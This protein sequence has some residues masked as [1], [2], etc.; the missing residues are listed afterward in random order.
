MDIQNLKDY[1][2]ENG[3][4]STVLENLGCHHIAKK[5][6]YYTAGNPDGD[7]PCA[8]SVYE[9][10]YLTTVNYTRNI[11]DNKRSSDIFDLVQFFEEC[12]FFSAVKVVCDW[13]GVDYYSDPTDDLPE[14]LRITK[15]ILDMQKGDDIEDEDKP[16]RPISEKIL[17]YYL[18]CVNDMFK[19]DGISYT[20]QQEFEIGYDESTN[21]ITIPIRDELGTL[22]GVKGRQMKHTFQKDEN[23]YYY[24]EHTNRS[25]IL[26]GLNKTA[27]YI[28]H[29]NKV[30]VTESEKGVMQ[31]WSMGICNAVA[32]SGKKVS[33][34][35]IDKL[36]RLCADV[37]F[38]FDK[39]VTREEISE[40]ADRF[41]DCVNIYAVIDTEKVLDEKESP[42]DN[43]EKFEYLIK[44]NCERIR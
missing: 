8:I 11:C 21:C 26:Y 15:M 40:L 13:I 37:I 43:A 10:E 23:K 14:S 20:T 12:N 27:P 44:N 3:L 42:T 18:P 5:A 6:G 7:N 2:I 31:L 36:T 32:T 16:V 39:D 30:Y 38:L 41:I 33:Q 17:T 19:V 9:S 28:S 1:I 22:V 25:K 29:S 34:A 24:L 4:I 35:Q